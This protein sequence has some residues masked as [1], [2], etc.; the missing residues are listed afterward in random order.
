M[1][2][3]GKRKLR[4]GRIA[5]AIALTIALA[6]GAFYLI[7]AEPVEYVT[8]QATVDDGESLWS[9]CYKIND[10]REDVRDVIRRAEEDNGLD[11]SGTVQ[12]GQVLNIRVKN[13][14][15]VR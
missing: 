15:I 12:P 9:I 1:R 13:K 7:R 4:K 14:A 2:K 8:Y 3:I 5:C 10:D 6:A 11:A